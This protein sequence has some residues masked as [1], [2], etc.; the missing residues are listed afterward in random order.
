MNGTLR[1]PAFRGKHFVVYGGPYREAEPDMF[2]VK[3]AVEIALPCDL[4]LPIKDF[5]VPDEEMLIETLRK[6][7]QRIGD[8]EAVYV[9]CMGGRGRTGLFLAML[10]KAWGIENPIQY[11]RQN[12]YKHA[13]ETKA[14]ELFVLMTP[15]PAWLK[16]Q[17]VFAKMQGFWRR[18][19]SLTKFNEDWLKPKYQYSLPS[20]GSFDY[21][22]YYSYLYGTPHKG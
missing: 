3:L 7:V 20:G 18:G 21:A 5:S 16:T 13:V 4:S 1:L 19:P 9:G 2:G 15:I 14:Q 11:V 22:A 6:V 12:Y 10:A 17:V 8:G